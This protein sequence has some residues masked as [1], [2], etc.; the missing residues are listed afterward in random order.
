MS[1]CILIFSWTY[2][3]TFFIV[4][5]EA[6]SSILV[7]DVY[8]VLWCSLETKVEDVVSCEVMVR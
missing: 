5:L 3:P 4:Y 6:S 7:R 2:F 1:Y 8:D